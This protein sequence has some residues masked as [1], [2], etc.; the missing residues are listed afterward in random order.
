MKIFISWSGE[1]SHRVALALHEWLPLVINAINP[2]VS[3]EDIAKGIDWFRDIH[4]N[5]SE[6]TF[7][8]VC[9][10]RENI[11][12]PWILFEAGAIA[13]KLGASFL[14]P[15]LVDLSPAD[16][17]NPLSKLQATKVEKEDVFKLLKTINSQLETGAL[18]ENRLRT[19]FDKWWDDLLKKIE[20]AKAETKELSE[21]K[22]KPPKRSDRE[23]LEETLEIVRGLSQTKQWQEIGVKGFRS[24]GKGQGLLRRKSL[25]EVLERNLKDDNRLTNPTKAVFRFFGAE[26]VD[27]ARKVERLILKDLNLYLPQTS[28]FEDDEGLSVRVEFGAPVGRS[29]IIDLMEAVNKLN[30]KEVEST[31]STA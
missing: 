26:R 5:L 9:V 11:N 29:L 12:R 27:N 25:S 7:G 14:T 30:I 6:S 2:Y 16:I 31:F 3:S 21:N 28:V 17:D 15:L 18:D 4:T 10:T 23:I 20:K 19:A 13:S 8:I 22:E 1:L 24:S